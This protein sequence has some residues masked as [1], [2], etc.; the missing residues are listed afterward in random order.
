M[1]KVALYITQNLPF[2]RLYFYGKDRPLH[3]SFG[4]DQSRYIQYRRT[5]ENGDRVLAKVV[6]IDKAREYFADF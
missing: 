4:P 3:V 2:D 1:H 6:K 5:K